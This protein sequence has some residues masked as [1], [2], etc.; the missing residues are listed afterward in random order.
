MMKKRVFT[1]WD[2]DGDALDLM[3]ALPPGEVVW[4]DARTDLCINI[5]EVPVGPD[6][7]PVMDVTEWFDNLKEVYRLLWLNDP[8]LNMLIT[9]LLY[10]YKKKGLCFPCLSEVIDAFEKMDTA[11]GSKDEDIKQKLINRQVGI[12]R[13]LPSL[14]VHKSRNVY[15]LFSEHSVIID[16][17]RI[18]DTA[19]IFLY[20][21]MSLVFDNI[22]WN[23]NNEIFRMEFFEEAH[24]LLSDAIDKRTSDLKDSKSTSRFRKLR[25]SGTCG[26][27]ISQKVDDVPDAILAN[28]NTMICFRQSD[29][30]S[31][32]KAANKM[33]LKPWQIEELATLPQKEAIVKLSRES[34]PI[35]VRIKDVY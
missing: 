17:S 30:N 28:L 6:N 22:F 5:F 35:R 26:I 13:S 9:V 20:N 25:K 7:K 31:L 27:V 8:S 29:R 21:F 14:D 23:D 33:N 10:L 18:S 15:R 19:R 11:R 32:M 34:K 12:C 4:L 3:A 16:I 24:E 1:Y 2:S